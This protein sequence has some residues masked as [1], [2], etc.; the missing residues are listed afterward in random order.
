[1]GCSRG[2]I[3]HKN[4]PN[5]RE[6]HIVQIGQSAAAVGDATEQLV[7]NGIHVRQLL[8][9]S[10]ADCGVVTVSSPKREAYD[11]NDTRCN[12]LYV[13]HCRDTAE[14]RCDCCCVI[15]AYLSVFGRQYHAM[16]A[17][18]PWHC[19]SLSADSCFAVEPSSNLHF[20][21]HR[22]NKGLNME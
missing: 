16:T 22:A 18:W 5:N 8:N 3:R 4:K 19:W 11:N 2:R 20:T 1:V 14:R 10:T 17:S 9:V 12:F 6:G 21:V 13:Q 7:R 15:S